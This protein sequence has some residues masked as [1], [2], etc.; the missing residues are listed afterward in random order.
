MLNKCPKQS[1]RYDP[2]WTNFLQ[3]KNENQ[4]LLGPFLLDFHK[5]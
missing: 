4:S 5:Q 2:V 3:K 1:D